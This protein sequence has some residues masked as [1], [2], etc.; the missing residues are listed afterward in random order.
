MNYKLT[1][2]RRAGYLH[3]VVTGQNSKETVTAYLAHLLRE[4]E[5]RD[6]FKVLLEEYLDEPHTPGMGAIDFAGENDPLFAIDPRAISF[7][8]HEGGEEAQFATTVAANRDLTIACF[9]NVADAKKWLLRVDAAPTP[10][11]IQ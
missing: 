11:R 8:Q 9:A 10:V 6:C 1:I 4:C 3:A 7:P 2:D 5:R